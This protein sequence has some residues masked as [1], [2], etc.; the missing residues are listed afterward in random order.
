MHWIC[1]SHHCESRW[2]GDI[3][4]LIRSVK[5][6]NFTDAIR[7]LERFAEGNEENEEVVILS[8]DNSKPKLHNPLKEDLL[9]YLRPLYTPLVNRGF[10]EEILKKYG[11][12]FWSRPGTFMNNRLI[13]P[14]RDIDGY[15]VGFSGRTIFSKEM[16]EEKQIDYKKWIHGRYYH[17]FPKKGEFYTS[18][19]MYNLFSSKNHLGESRKMVLVEGPLDGYKLSMAGINN[20]V[21]TFGTHISPAQIT[22]LLSANV[23]SLYIAYDNDENLAGQ[24]ASSNV[25]KKASDFFH[26]YDIELP[27]G[28]DPGSLS[29]DE[30]KDVFK[31]CLN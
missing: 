22:L 7:W 29:V 10:S 23:N 15:L 8:Y 28:Q 6:L 1:W 21:A 17:K 19:L 12:G 25:K 9:S 16:F 5:N 4:G 26:L 13:F 3:I 14:I 27:D 20:W 31:S 11:V 30:V 2:G 18:S 24:I